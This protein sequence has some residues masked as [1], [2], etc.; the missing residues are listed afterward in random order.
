[1]ENVVEEQGLLQNSFH[2]NLHSYFVKKLQTIIKSHSSMMGVSNLAISISPTMLFP[3]L[4]FIM[5]IIL[6]KVGH[7]MA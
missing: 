2:T 6:R 1:M 4:A 7:A 5:P 3:F